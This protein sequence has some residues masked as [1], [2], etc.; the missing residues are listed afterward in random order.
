M[1]ALD[2]FNT[3]REEIKLFKTNL[4]KD[5]QLKRS[6]ADHNERK[7]KVLNDFQI[8]FNKLRDSISKDLSNVSL[9]DDIKIYVT[10]IDNIIRESRLILDNRA[11]INLVNMGESFSLKTAGSLLPVM[12]GNEDTTKQL[13][14]SI[15]LY[16]DMLRVDD[17][18][19]LINFVLKS[20]LTSNA[21]VRLNKTYA[22]VDLLVK[23][24]QEHFI[25]KRSAIVL[26]NQLHQCSQK[27]KTI[28]E[29]GNEIE[30]L[31]SELTLAQSGNDDTL[32]QALRP[33]NE[34]IAINSFTNGIRNHDIRTILKARNCS[35]LKE[36]ISVAKNEE[37]NKPSSSAI[38]YSKHRNYSYNKN[39]NEYGKRNFQQQNTKQNYS[40]RK[41]FSST[42]GR[43]NNFHSAET[44][45]NTVGHGRG[46]SNVYY[47]ETNNEA[48]ND[49]A[50][51]F[52]VS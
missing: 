36:A 32:L 42:R 1:N 4:L 34:P 14:D 21:K 16:A 49:N 15:I 13:L 48:Q 9:L 40:F 17:K 25:T 30:Q 47:T 26:S 12:D 20:R 23:D 50:R 22:S 31:L 37:R 10:D 41:E 27:E 29:F 52:R 18:K 38:F 39:R 3:L 28:D 44:R 6:N 2:Y 35:T 24:I 33:V 45:S 19:H 43:G 46:R 5:N 7:S 11:K 51:F 8:R